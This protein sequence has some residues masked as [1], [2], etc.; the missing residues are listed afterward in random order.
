MHTAEKQSSADW[1]KVQVCRPDSC[2]SPSEK[3]AGISGSGLDTFTTAAN[4]NPRHHLCR[5]NF[6]I[7]IVLILVSFWNLNLEIRELVLGLL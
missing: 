1:E 2:L 5:Q 6:H 7:F 3:T 4:T